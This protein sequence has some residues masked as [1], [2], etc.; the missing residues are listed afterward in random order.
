VPLPFDPKGVF[1]KARAPVRGTV[2]GA[3]FRSTVAI[4]GGVAY[5]GVTKALREEAGATSVTRSTSRSS[6]TTRRARSTFRPSSRQSSNVMRRPRARSRSCRTRSERSTRV[7]SPT[8][9]APKRRNAASPRS[10]RCF[11]KAFPR[12]TLRL[13]RRSPVEV[14]V[15]SPDLGSPRPGQRATS[16]S[17]SASMPFRAKAS[18]A[19]AA[20]AA[21]RCSNR[22]SSSKRSASSEAPAGGD[23]ASRV[24]RTRP[25]GV[26]SSN[27]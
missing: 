24:P 20:A 10:Q 17:Q 5:L 1:G 23:A 18:F 19:R 9:S 14:A 13:H 3:P 25:K 22:R 7:G 21:S 8:R 26:D 15:A 12:P 4:Y 27:R 2:N 6:S 11:A 16:T